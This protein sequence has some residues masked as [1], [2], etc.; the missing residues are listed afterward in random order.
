MSNPYKRVAENHS[1][2]QMLIGSDK[3]SHQLDSPEMKSVKVNLL[4]TS[5][6]QVFQQV[7]SAVSAW[8]TKC[9]ASAFAFSISGLVSWSSEKKRK[10]MEITVEFHFLRTRHLNDPNDHPSYYFTNTESFFIPPL[11]KKTKGPFPHN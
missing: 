11:K 2:I 10:T 7:L 1:N 5:Q 6:F 4:S 9:S 3:V 8:A